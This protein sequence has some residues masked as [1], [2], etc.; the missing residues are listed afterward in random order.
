MLEK[1]EITGNENGKTRQLIYS[2]ETYNIKALHFVKQ[3]NAGASFS[4]SLLIWS[5]I[6]NVHK[7]PKAS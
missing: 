1:K 5:D 2:L 6:H 4:N 3:T 7:N